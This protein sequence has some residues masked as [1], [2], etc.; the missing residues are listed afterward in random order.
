LQTLG[1]S[2][3]SALLDPA[4]ADGL[5]DTAPVL[6][7]VPDFAALLHSGEDAALSD[8]LRRSESTGR[9]LG[10]S[11]FLHRVEAILGRDPR[12]AKQLA[13]LLRSR[14]W[15]QALP[16]RASVSRGTKSIT[17]LTMPKSQK[18]M[19]GASRSLFT[20]ITTPDRS[21]PSL[22]WIWP[23]MPHAT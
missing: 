16:R 15:V 12:P 9:P 5:T 14:A 3:V 4:R 20:A 23:E 7:R 8:A 17:S 19:I 13:P 18:P 1:W 11:E 6:E 21:M 22:C 10:A 2:S